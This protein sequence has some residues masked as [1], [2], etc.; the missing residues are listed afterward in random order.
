MDSLTIYLKIAAIVL[1]EVLA[2]AIFWPT[3]IIIPCAYLIY[4]KAKKKK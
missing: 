3:A 1:I 2:L 4:T